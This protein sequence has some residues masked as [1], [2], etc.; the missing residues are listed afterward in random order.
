[1][2][3]SGLWYSST[4]NEE[5]IIKHPSLFRTVFMVLLVL[6]QNLVPNLL[7]KVFKK[8]KKELENFASPSEIILLGMPLKNKSAIYDAILEILPTTTN[9]ESQSLFDLGK[10]NTK[11]IDMPVQGSLAIGKGVYKL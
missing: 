9:I 3:S 2:T 6:K 4:Y 10:P 7:Y 11:S 8:R 1:M 5:N